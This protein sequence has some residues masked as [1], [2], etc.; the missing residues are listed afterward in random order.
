[1][2]TQVPHKIKSQ[3][4]LDELL[5][6]EDITVLDC[7]VQLNH[8]IRTSKDITLT[9]EGDYNVFNYIDDTEEVILHDELMDSII[10]EAITKGAFY[11][12]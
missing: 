12:Y 5:N 1:M 10:G 6:N 11:R 7:F 3:E 8:S 9:D 4:E 2:E